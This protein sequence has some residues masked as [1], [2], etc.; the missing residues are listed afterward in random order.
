MSRNV[1]HSSSHESNSNRLEESEL[2]VE[3]VAEQTSVLVLLEAIGAV[4]S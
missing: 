3:T 1:S 4:V 2:T